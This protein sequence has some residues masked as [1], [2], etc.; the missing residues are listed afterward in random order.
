MNTDKK[1]VRYRYIFHSFVSL[2]IFII[3]IH[4]NNTIQL[5]AILFLL[6]KKIPTHKPISNE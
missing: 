4:L 6:I 1:I 2:Y 3:A 5:L